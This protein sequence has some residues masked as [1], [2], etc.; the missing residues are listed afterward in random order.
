MSSTITSPRPARTTLRRLGVVLGAGL[1]TSVALTG[2]AFAHV[3]ITPDS[4]PGGEDAE[5]AFRVPTESDSAS[6]VKVKILMPKNHPIPGVAT[7][8]IPG[9]T[10]ATKTRKLSKPIDLEGEKVDTV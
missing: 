4:V 10:V 7:T 1:L 2:V 5:I 3:E 9:W 8:N 6:T